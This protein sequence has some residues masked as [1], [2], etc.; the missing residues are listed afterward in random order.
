MHMFIGFRHHL[1]S[2]VVSFVFLTSIFTNFCINI[3]NLTLDQKIGQLFMVAAV[4]DEYTAFRTLLKKR[5]KGCR[6]H[7]R[8]IAHL[9][10]DF[11]IGGIIYLGKSDPLKQKER[12]DYFQSLS[13]IPLVIGQDLEPGRVGSYIFSLMK[14][15]PN[16]EVLGNSDDKE[17]T[18]KIGLAIGQLCNMLGVHIN[19]APVADVNNNPRNPVINDRSFGAEPTVVAAHAIAFSNGLHDAGIIACVKHFPGHGDTDVDSHRDLPVIAHDEKRLHDVE[20]YPFKQLI[21]AQI[22]MIMMGHLAVP[23]F[24]A[25]KNV[26]SSLSKNI[27]TK[28][29]RQELGFTG[30]IVTDALDMRGVTRYYSNGQAELHALLAGND[31]LLCPINVPKAVAAIKQAIKNGVITEQEIDEHVQR[32]L[33]LKKSLGLC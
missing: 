11:G 22:P 10:R 19:F 21:A 12:T 14:D 24:E 33:E 16:N 30:I 4:A 7:K 9:I 13:D 15:F 26:P 23:A 25:Q 18:Y 1:L 17:F 5:F 8:H 32:I 2:L 3:N 20:L 27:V 28:L 29:L 31:I 6:L